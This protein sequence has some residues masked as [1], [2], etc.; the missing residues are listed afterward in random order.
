[1]TKRELR[2]ECLEQA[3]CSECPFFD[4]CDLENKVYDECDDDYDDYYEETGN[5]PCDNYGM[6]A[7]STCS[8]YPKCQGWEK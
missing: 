2:R 5:M 7:G 6:C 4:E 3:H 1:M 8:N